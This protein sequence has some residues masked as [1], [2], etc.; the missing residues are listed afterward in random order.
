MLD[1]AIQVIRTKTEVIDQTTAN[2]ARLLVVDMHRHTPNI[3]AD[4]T[5]SYERGVIHHLRA[6]H[7]CIER[8]RFLD[9]R[10]ENMHMI[11]TNH[12]SSLP[13]DCF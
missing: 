3:E 13:A 9:V 8:N 6:E 12:L 7:G 11:K 1:K 5:L 4:V 2:T 10:R